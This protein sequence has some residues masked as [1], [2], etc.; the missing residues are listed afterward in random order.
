[1]LP[2]RAPRLARAAVCRRAP[3]GHEGPPAGDRALGGLPAVL[4]RL[5]RAPRGRPLEPAP[6][7][8]A[9]LPPR[10]GGRAR[11]GAR[12]DRPPLR[13]DAWPERHAA[14]SGRGL[15]GAP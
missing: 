10:R 4:A 8:G 14:A 5:A 15:A 3:L 1:A 12:G 9:S 2:P 11:P 6:R 7:A 13:E